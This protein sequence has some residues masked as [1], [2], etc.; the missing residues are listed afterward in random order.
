MITGQLTVWGLHDSTLKHVSEYSNSDQQNT[1]CLAALTCAIGFGILGSLILFFISPLLGQ[2]LQSQYVE[3]GLLYLSPGIAFF[4]T[5]KVLNAIFNGKQQMKHFAL[6]SS[7][8]AI[9]ILIFCLGL[10]LF[11][12][13]YHYFGL[14]FTVSEILLFVVILFFKPI[15]FSFNKNQFQNWI[16]KHL[17]FGSRSVIHG[18]FSEAFIRIDILMLGFFLSDPKVG[19][20]SFAAFFLEG[21]Y[22][23]PVV[24]RNLN[25]PI[26]VKMLIDK[27]RDKLIKFTRKTASFSLGLTLLGSALIAIIYPHLDL[28]FDA[29]TIRV[30]YPILLVLL[31]GMV[32]YSV[33]IPFDYIFITGGRP[34][35]QS[36]FMSLNV[37]VNVGLNYYLIP[38]YG[39]MGAG[40]ATVTSF[41]SASILL[42]VFSMIFLRLPRG[43][44][45]K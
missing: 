23:I 31:G 40:I 43:I 1:L 5:N 6:V 25:N 36:G 20:Y 10:I 13:P 14:V 33:S 38:L 39:L 18:L 11:R 26:L 30:S 29:E 42:N 27:N 28:F 15:D 3:E 45:V 44:F 24:V 17:N 8:R 12:Q 35:I 32:I 4:V 9:S 34:G 19:I 21:L 2:A 16:K 7:V 37:A 41:I 22:Q